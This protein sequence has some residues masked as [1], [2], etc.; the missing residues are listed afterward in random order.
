VIFKS[1][2][3]NAHRDIKH[4]LIDLDLQDMIKLCLGV[5]RDGFLE[6]RSGEKNREI[7]SFFIECFC[8]K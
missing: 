4:T 7:F 1:Y 8:R 3:R 2:T 6:E 5:G